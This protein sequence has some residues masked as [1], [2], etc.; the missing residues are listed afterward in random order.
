MQNFWTFDAPGGI[1]SVDYQLGLLDDAGII[2][3]GVVGHDDDAV[4]LAQIFQLR[5]LQLQVV[6]PT[7][8]DEWELGIVVADLGSIFLQKLDDG[9]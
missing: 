1:A 5:A 2:V 3:I 7:F 6:F 9:E 8:A 4:I